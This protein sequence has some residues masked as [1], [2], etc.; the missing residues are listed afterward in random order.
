MVNGFS[1]MYASNLITILKSVSLVA[2]YC[3]YVFVGQIHNALNLC[4]LELQI[5]ETR[6]LLW[7]QGRVEGRIP[8]AKRPYRLL[9]SH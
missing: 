5:H 1:C 7:S 3:V 4:V 2:V 9:C 6:F 8:P